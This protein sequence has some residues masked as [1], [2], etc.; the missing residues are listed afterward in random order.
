MGRM[1]SHFPVNCAK[2][3][4]SPS[5][6]EGQGFHGL[7]PSPR[8][9]VP[10]GHASP[11]PARSPSRPRELAGWLSEED[12]DSRA[13]TPAARTARSSRFSLS[14]QAGKAHS[15]GGGAGLG[16]NPSCLRLALGEGAGRAQQAAPEAG[17]A[18]SWEKPLWK[19]P[20]VPKE[21]KA[22]C[23]PVQRPRLVPSAPPSS[24]LTC[25]LAG[26]GLAVFPAPT[27]KRHLPDLSEAWARV[28]RRKWN[29]SGDYSGALGQK[30][31][32]PSHASMLSANLDLS[33]QEWTHFL[34]RLFAV[35][36]SPTYRLVNIKALWTPTL[37]RFV[38]VPRQ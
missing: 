34:C 27:L 32:T 10:S 5:E 38:K 18:N 16:G 24:A 29:C 25:D 31:P 33:A 19:T 3:P 6:G 9:E 13:R 7:L 4:G 1:I 8:P 22:C 15:P 20:N 12:C 36:Q 2:V 30:S 28:L 37:C 14:L 26:P 11:A 23:S 35:L 17:R 21:T